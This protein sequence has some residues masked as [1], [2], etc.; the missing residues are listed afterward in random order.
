MKK[1]K[2]RIKVEE[3]ELEVEVNAPLE[4]SKINRIIKFLWELQN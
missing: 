1:Q 4:Q 3:I 2:F